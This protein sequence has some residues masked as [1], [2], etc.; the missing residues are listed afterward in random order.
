MRTLPGV[1]TAGAINHLPLSGYNWMT[2]VRRDD[3][4]LPPGVSPPTSEWRMIDGSYFEAMRIPLLAGRLFTDGDDQASPPVAI[5][6]DVFAR[7]FFGSP[8][9]ALG[10]VVRT[11]SASGETT[12]TIVGVVGG[13][14]HRALS[15]PPAPELYR[16]IAQSFAVA[17]AIVIKT[18]GAPAALAPAAQAAIREVDPSLPVADVLPL[19]TLLQNSLLKPRL[20][21]ILLLMFA[22]AGLAIVVSGAYGVVAYTVQRREREFGIRLAIG[23][24]PAEIWRLVIRQGAMYAAAGLSVGLPIALLA[25]GAVRGLLFG[26]AAR[27]L[28]TFAAV[29]GAIAAITIAAT[30]VPA[31]RAFRVRPASVLRAD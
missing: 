6:N 10:R 3:Q 8:S 27:D 15:V 23:A 2:T 12:P 24:V 14:R 30:L 26:I 7:R 29:S 19:S 21:A 5:V 1:E 25:T 17:S 18:T 9:A 11:G 16:P 20:L 13:V 4:P 22:G 31:A 28:P